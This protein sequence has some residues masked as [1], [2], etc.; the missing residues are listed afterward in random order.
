MLRNYRFVRPTDGT[1]I[2]LDRFIR[3]LVH[4]ASWAL[5]R[6]WIQSGK[7]SVDGH[8]TVDER[9]VVRANSEV[10]IDPRAARA[11]RSQATLVKLVH[12]DAQVAVV[13]KPAGV[14]TVPFDAN[15]RD[16]L[17]EL[18]RRELGHR[19]GQR[20][21]PLG[22]VHRIDKA[23]SGLVVFARTT[24]AKRHLKQQFRFHTIHRL[25]MAL[26]HGRVES[27]T[28]RS[29][30][31]ADR[32]DGRRGSTNHGDMGQIAVTH[33]ETVEHLPNA[34]L[35]H[36]RLETGRTHQIRIH[37]AEIG[38]P[39]LGERVYASPAIGQ[40]AL[41]PRQMLHASELGFRHPTRDTELRF[42]SELPPDFQAVLRSLRSGGQ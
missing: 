27:Q 40:I 4:G 30:L 14:S 20:P 11:S 24:V 38:H 10:T 15:E 37:L 18:V 34:T 8:V 25:Y 7:V 2:A 33:V 39:L 31:V 13:E 36:C 22:I 1:P 35:L 29:R 19:T 5:V 6:S 26:A 42:T 16:T 21:P 41:P 12:V 28:I 32:G 17:D 9:A 3:E 23:T